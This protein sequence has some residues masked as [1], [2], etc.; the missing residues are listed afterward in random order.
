LTPL[1]PRRLT[2]AKLAQST[3]LRA[4]RLAASTASAA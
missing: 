4:L 2:V 3:R 1:I